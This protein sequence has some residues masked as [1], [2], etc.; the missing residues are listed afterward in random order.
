MNEQQ[1]NNISP[2]DQE[3]VTKT[4]KINKSA[5]KVAYGKITQKKRNESYK[6]TIDRTQNELSPF[7]KLFSKIIH[8]KLFEIFGDFLAKTIARP[9]AL[10]AGA[11]TSFFLTL[12]VYIIAKTIGFKLSGFE[13]I[14]AFV[15]G[16][17]IG[18][19]YDYFSLFSFKK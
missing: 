9:N 6:K 10:L 12:S 3:I 1:N 17:I 15:I 19:I 8:I 14:S 16:W 13:T 11:A 4:I 18:I 7:S 5:K 2:R